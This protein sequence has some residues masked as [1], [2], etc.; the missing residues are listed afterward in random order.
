MKVFGNLGFVEYTS[1][2]FSW[3][4]FDF[5]CSLLNL[6]PSKFGV[7]WNGNWPIRNYIECFWVS[8]H[9]TIIISYNNSPSVFP[10]C[11]VRNCMSCRLEYE[12]CQFVSEQN[13]KTRLYFVWEVRG[14][15]KV[16][17]TK[18]SEKRGKIGSF[19]NIL[20]HVKQFV[21]YHFSVQLI[22][23]L[24]ALLRKVF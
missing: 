23:P 11:C 5:N 1:N 22:Y 18:I 4:Q 15:P 24:C 17:I 12:R 16:F 14:H 21:N 20:L 13:K 6:L 19:T 3:N 10:F 2:D 9:V 7:L 8:V